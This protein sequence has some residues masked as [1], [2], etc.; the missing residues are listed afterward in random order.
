MLARPAGF[1]A[2]PGGT[3]D[4]GAA[5][6]AGRTAVVVG[7]AL[8]LGGAAYGPIARRGNGGTGPRGLTHNG[9]THG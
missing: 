7:A 2:L 1:A 3:S 6:A 8:I 9:G 5:A 4:R